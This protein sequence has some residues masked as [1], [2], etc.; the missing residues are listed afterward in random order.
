[1]A[2]LNYFKVKR[3]PKESSSGPSEEKLQ[4]PDPHGPL[5]E[6]VPSSAIEAA[7]QQVAEVLTAPV[8]REPYFKSTPAQR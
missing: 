8:S 6:R 5:S 7:N 1:M 2:L 3:Q 4:L